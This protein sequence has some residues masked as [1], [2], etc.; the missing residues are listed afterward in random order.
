[1][2]VLCLQEKL[3]APL[4]PD[5]FESLFLHNDGRAA[6]GPPTP[7]GY[8]TLLTANLDLLASPTR[9]V[10]PCTQTHLS[11]CACA[12]F[13]QFRFLPS[14]CPLLLGKYPCRWKHINCVGRTACKL[15]W[16]C[17]LCGCS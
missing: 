16:L 11:P 2:L 14:R 5:V 7:A 8:R 12:P 1:M 6:Q 13:A 15:L 3:V 10:L 17:G 9:E 4:R